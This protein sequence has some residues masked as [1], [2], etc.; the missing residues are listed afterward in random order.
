MT[1]DPY[2][3]D[4]ADFDPPDSTDSFDPYMPRCCLCGQHH[5]GGTCG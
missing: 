1:I 4:E 2:E 5:Y 3:S